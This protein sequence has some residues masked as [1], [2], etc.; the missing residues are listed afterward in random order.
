MERFLQ[1]YGHKYF[2]EV[3]TRYIVPWNLVPG[4]TAF[5][6][7][8]KIQRNPYVVHRIKNIAQQGKHI[9][10]ILKGFGI[11]NVLPT[12]QFL[13]MS[14]DEYSARRLH[15]KLKL[16]HPGDQMPEEYLPTGWKKKAVQAWHKNHKSDER[17]PVYPKELVA[18]AR[19]RAKEMSMNVKRMREKNTED[20]NSK[21][22]A[23]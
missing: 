20:F 1:S 23:T 10:M 7:P 5:Y 6:N 19:A 18:E 16:K 8:V 4:S 13:T 12:M 14:L 21:R 2:P 3:E 17:M 22:I 9:N 15:A 11:Q